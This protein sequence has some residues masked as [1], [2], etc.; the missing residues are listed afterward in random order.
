[1]DLDQKYLALDLELNNAPDGSTPNPSIIQVG[2]AIGSARQ[3]PS[4][5]IVKKWFVKVNE[6]IYTFITELTGITTEDVQ[7]GLQ[8][9]DIANEL[10]NLIKDNN[11]FVNPVTW[12][13]G[14]STELKADFER[15]GVEFRNFGR[16]WI[17]VKTWY[18]LH[19]ITKGKKPAGGLS[20][21][22]GEYKMHF[23][24]TPHRADVDA[25]NTLRL[26]FQ[27]LKKQ[28]AMENLIKTAKEV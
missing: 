19:M 13:G 20:S 9:Y 4:D 21:A 18:V 16:R 12:G 27:I 17:D 22:M 25:Y 3:L 7:N 11:T 23:E 8:H 6:P 26:F 10:N 28:G 24:G 1:M 5:W 14:D 15:W 2:V